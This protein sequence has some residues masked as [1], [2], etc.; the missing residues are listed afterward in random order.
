QGGLQ[1]GFLLENKGSVNGSVVYSVSLPPSQQVTNPTLCNAGSASV[2][3]TLSGSQV[4]LTAN[5]GG[6]TFTLTGTLSTDGQSMTG[7]AT[8]TDGPLVPDPT[9]PQSTV[10][11]G[12]AQS[13][14]TWQAAL[15]PPLNGTVSGSLHSQSGALNNQSFAVTGF[16]NQ[17]LNIG[18]SSATV[19]GLLTFVDPVTQIPL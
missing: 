13:T 1:G 17:G 19:T 3:G 8:S 18:A 5:A 7:T 16:L 15:V 6:Q 12:T 10:P 2:T 9:N 11:C 14:L 4:T